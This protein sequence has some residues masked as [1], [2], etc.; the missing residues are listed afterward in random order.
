LSGQGDAVGK[1]I[2]PDE[3]DFFSFGLAVPKP[4]PPRARSH[5]PCNHRQEIKLWS[6][7]WHRSWHPMRIAEVARGALDEANVVRHKSLTSKDADGRPI[8]LDK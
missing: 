1:P 2:N 6:G 4:E 7:R 3:M 8:A 5:C